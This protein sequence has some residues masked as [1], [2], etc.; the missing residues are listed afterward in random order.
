MVGARSVSEKW[1]GLRETRTERG[2]DKA[3]ERER[4]RRRDRDRVS[5]R[6]TTCAR[7]T[8][9]HGRRREREYRTGKERWTH[10]QIQSVNI[11]PISS[12]EGAERERVLY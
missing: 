11:T 4:D 2:S 1:G 5:E 7:G 8:G 9:R 6:N 12:G 10:P 3:S